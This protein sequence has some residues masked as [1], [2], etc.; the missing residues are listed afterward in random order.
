ML[1]VC[2]ATLAVAVS[3]GMA[4]VNAN[5]LLRFALFPEPMSCPRFCRIIED[6]FSEDEEITSNIERLPLQPK[7]ASYLVPSIDILRALAQG[8]QRF[9]NCNCE[10]RLNL[11]TRWTICFSG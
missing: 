4:R 5:H 11:I 7:Y 3:P 1:L 6:D 9:G 10:R 8:R 2:S